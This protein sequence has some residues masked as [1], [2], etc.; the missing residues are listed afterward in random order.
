MLFRSIAWFR[1]N[2][3]NSGNMAWEFA[4]PLPHPVTVPTA[5]TA[6]GLVRVNQTTAAYY[7]HRLREL[8]YR[9]VADAAPFVGEIEVDE[10]Y[11]GG[12]RKGQRGRGAAGKLPVL[13]GVWHHHQV[14]MFVRPPP[15]R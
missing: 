12:H 4:A 6:A 9:A 8:I 15:C 5:R 2:W 3:T 1:F 7:Y 13:I 14:N 10:S 11:F